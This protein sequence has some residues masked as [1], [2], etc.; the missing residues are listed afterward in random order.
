[1]PGINDFV[2]TP[3]LRFQGVSSMLSA[4]P[5]QNAA[6]APAMVDPTTQVAGKPVSE[7]SRPT[8]CVRSVRLPLTYTLPC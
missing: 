4:D 8:P 1:M 2:G 5:A 6:P 7:T 3:G